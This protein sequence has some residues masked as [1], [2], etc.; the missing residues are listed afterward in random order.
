M[1]T[2]DSLTK[3]VHLGTAMFLV[4]EYSYYKCFFEFK[5]QDTDSKLSL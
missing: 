3:L 4:E 2:V 1:R 5:Y